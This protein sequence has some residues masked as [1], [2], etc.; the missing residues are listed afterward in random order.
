[1]KP[2]SVARVGLGKRIARER[3]KGSR[4]G[5]DRPGGMGLGGPGRSDLFARGIAHH[6]TRKTSP[7]AFPSPLSRCSRPRAARPAG[8]AHHRTRKTS[9]RAFPSFLSRCSRPR[10]AHPARERRNKR[11]GSTLP[12]RHQTWSIVRKKCG[13]AEQVPA[14]G[15]RV[16]HC[17]GAGGF[18]AGGFPAGGLP[19]G[20][21][22]GPC[23]SPAPRA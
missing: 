10:A 23:S 14:G 11:I 3:Y 1:M 20:G 15:S 8:I 6:R 17:G 9:P 18:P 19:A 16:P 21:T 2:A 13:G 7:R 22:A 12:S 5:L 4:G